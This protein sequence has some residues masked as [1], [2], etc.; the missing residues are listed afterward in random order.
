[1]PSTRLKRFPL[2]GHNRTL[3]S[4]F[5]DPHLAKRLTPLAIAYDF[6]GTLAPGNMQEFDFV[7]KIGMKPADFWK[8]VAETAK[9]HNA[10]NI[11]VYM[12]LMIQRAL[13]KHVSVRRSDFVQFGK[14]VHLFDGV[15]D[16][17]SRIDN[18][19]KLHGV[20]IQH[21]IVSSGIREMIEGTTIARHFKRIYASSFW[22]DHNGVAHWPAMAL[23]YTT[24]TQYLFRINKGALDVWD[25]SVINAYVKHDD[26]PI[27]FNNMVYIGDGETDVPCFRLMK[28]QGG[29]AIAVYKPHSKGARDKADQLLS[30]GRVH[31]T[32]PANYVDGGELDRFVKAI[33]VR[34][35]SDG[36]LK[37]LG[38]QL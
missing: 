10:D 3:H 31:F 27:P 7:P 16:W 32:A 30:D 26:R 24:K 13:A 14:T 35:A 6:D 4:T 33:V 23:N 15:A 12:G 18:F 36:E 8:E 25:N 38:K 37:R 20:R 22:Y 11:L 1:M 17:F 19:G 28:D 34:V 21:F 2:Y 5:G 9:L 29:H